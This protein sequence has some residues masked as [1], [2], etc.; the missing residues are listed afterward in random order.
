[1]VMAWEYKS[2]TIRSHYKIAGLCRP[3]MAD[4]K[5]INSKICNSK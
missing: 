2:Q 4:T 5:D 3:L 1:M